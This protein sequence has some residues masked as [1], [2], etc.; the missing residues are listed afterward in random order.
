[1]KFILLPLFYLLICGTTITAQC[2]MGDCNDGKGT[3][4]YNDNS[5]YSGDFK[6]SQADGYGK[7]NYR[8]G[9]SYEG[10]WKNH[11]Y[12]GEGIFINT[13]GVVT[14][15][16]WEKGTLTRVLNISYEEVPK[17]WAVIVGVANYRHVRSLKYA[18]DDAY[19]MYAFLKSPEGGAVAD[20]QLHLLVDE[21]AT[22]NNIIKSIQK[23]IAE[24][25]HNDLF[26]FYFSGH[27]QEDALLPFDYDGTYNH[28]F[29]KELNGLLQLSKAKHKICLADACN[30]GNSSGMY[31][32]KSGEDAS[33]TRIFTQTQKG[34][35]MM[36]ASQSNEKSEENS[37]LR[38]GT[39]SYFLIKGL[40]G[41]ADRNRDNLI[42][43]GELYDYVNRQVKSYTK[44][45]QHPSI[46]GNYN[47]EIA[48]G[49]V[50]GVARIDIAH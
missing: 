40:K 43:I 2:I 45:S 5:S 42:A 8:N 33:P 7:C 38:Q 27:G 20:E 18:D 10:H 48:V 46:F 28:L 4:V 12:H 9:N 1:M 24:A 14:K 49:R 23:V 36:I 30:S 41:E 13:E 32:M 39:F 3:Y 25:G 15:G 31:T 44:G 34:T 26:L 16:I 22:K 29:Y 35:V 21:Q 11:E 37:V 6:A 17:I 50:R 19:K 47:P